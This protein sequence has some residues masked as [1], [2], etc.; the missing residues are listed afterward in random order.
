[1]YTKTIY[2]TF[3]DRKSKSE[4]DENNMFWAFLLNHE[5]DEKKISVKI[6][7]LEA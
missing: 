4:Q 2:I 3:T 7:K 6:N 5:L 1:M